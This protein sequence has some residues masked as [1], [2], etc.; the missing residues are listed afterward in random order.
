MPAR[1]SE[2]GAAKPPL[3]RP[4]AQRGRAME[5]PLEAPA[6]DA[7]PAEAEPVPTATA[8][9]PVAAVSKAGSGRG[10]APNSRLLCLCVENL[11]RHF[12]AE[13]DHAIRAR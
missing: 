13:I 12:L 7:P 2:K 1:P 8:T 6:A 4:R 9:G 11:A 10:L 3:P 5:E